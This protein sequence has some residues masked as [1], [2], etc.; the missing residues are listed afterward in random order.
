[1]ISLLK[2]CWEGS[3]RRTQGEGT[4]VPPVSQVVQQ[5]S[6][7]EAAQLKGP[8]AAQLSAATEISDS[9]ADMV[10]SPVESGGE[11]G[12]VSASALAIDDG[13]FGLG[14]DAGDEEL[15]AYVTRAVRAQ[16]RSTDPL[17]L[18]WHEKMLLYDPIVVE[19]FA[20]W[21]NSGALTAVGCDAE[22]GVGEVKRWC[23]ERSVC[24]CARLG[25]DGRLRQRW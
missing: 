20:A 25:F 2:K 17:A 15:S 4:S 6:Q 10:P 11:S 9:E 18:S 14:S 22:V 12:G 16:P 7:S 24:C 23:R 5:A 19:D 13:D 21:L 3:Q 1:M 8:Q